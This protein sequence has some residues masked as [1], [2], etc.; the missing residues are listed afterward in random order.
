MAC[1]GAALV[2][3]PCGAVS[4][5]H[6]GRAPRPPQL[7]AGS[8]NFRT[9]VPVAAAAFRR[10]IYR[11][12]RQLSPFASPARS[13]LSGGKVSREERAMKVSDKAMELEA[14]YCA[15]NYEPL[16]VTLARGEG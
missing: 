13:Y 9:A 16:P 6:K 3:A 4:G 10:R 14:R 2:A 8:P 15:H 7:H 12:R 1:V 11:A 5:A